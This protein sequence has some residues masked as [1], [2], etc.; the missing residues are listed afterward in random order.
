MAE[1]NL[2]WDQ[3]IQMCRQVHLEEDEQLAADAFQVEQLDLETTEAEVGGRALERQRLLM[4]TRAEITEARAV[5]AEARAALAEAHR[6][7]WRLLCRR[8]HSRTPSS[9]IS[10]TTTRTYPTASSAP[11]TTT[12]CS[13]RSRP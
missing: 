12:F 2:S 13:R 8:P 1:H 7:W 11:V 3:V 5:L 9:T 4:A 10:P 6:R